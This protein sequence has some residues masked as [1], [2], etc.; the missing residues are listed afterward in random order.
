MKRI[1]VADLAERDL[2]EPAYVSITRI[3]T[4]R[5]AILIREF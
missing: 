3:A 4:I 2:D 5:R 1:R